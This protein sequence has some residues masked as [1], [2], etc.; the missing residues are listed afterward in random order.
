MKAPEAPAGFTSERQHTG[1]AYTLRVKGVGGRYCEG[2]AWAQLWG[3]EWKDEGDQ[4]TLTIVFASRVLV[5]TGWN[6][7]RLLDE[8]DEEALKGIQ[9]HSDAEVMLL[10]QDQEHP[11]IIESVTTAPT[12]PEI[13]NLITRKVEDEN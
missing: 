1:R 5:I 13:V 4:E 6:L 10:K 12:M 9:V 11:P 2:F 7:G 3:Y 8:I